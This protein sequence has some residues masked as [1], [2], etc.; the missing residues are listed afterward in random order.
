MKQKTIVIA[1]GG[2]GGHLYPTIAVAEEIRATHPEIRIV[3]IGTPNRIE[4]REVP[5]AGFEFRPIT[6][7]APGK[8][9]AQLLRFPF[10]YRLAYR[11]SKEILH[12]LD[13]CAFLGGG[14]YLSVPVAFAARRKRI[15]IALLE[16]NAVVG[17]ANKALSGSASKIFLSYPEAESE[18]RDVARRKIEII[19]TPVRTSLGE[20]MDS[21]EAREHFGLDPNKKTLLVF[22][23]SLGARSLNEAMMQ[24]TKK[25]LEAGMNVIWQTGASANISEIRNE[26]ESVS[27]L[28]ITDFISEMPIA[29]AA[30][31]L[32]VSRAGASTLAELAT[33]GKPAVLVPYPLAVKNHQEINAR[34]YESS[35][36]AKVIHDSELA[37][38]F[39]STVLELMADDE[40]RKKMSEKMRMRENITARNVVAQWLIRHCI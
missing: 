11:K 29:Y 33:L 3:F 12:E 7:S 8:S 19:G 10:Q 38:Y 5:K 21:S 40:Q 20:K 27:N 1:S 25:F 26:F 14:A 24:S 23:G 4:A 35:G 13:A 32:V 17:R 30:A 2:T 36:S 34:A 9:P 22:G 6:I 39:E 18:F 16:I 15:P 37:S 31:D 28:C